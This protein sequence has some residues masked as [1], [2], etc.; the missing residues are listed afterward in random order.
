MDRA[1]FIR[2]IKVIKTF[3]TQAFAVDTW[4]HLWCPR[5]MP[6]VVLMIFAGLGCLAS[7]EHVYAEGSRSLYPS[8]YPA[9][10]WRAN[11]DFQPGQ[12]YIGKVRRSGFLYVYAQAG[13]YI[14]LG[15]RNRS[16]GGDIFIDNPQDFGTPGDEIYNATTP[17]TPE[18]SCSAG[19]TEPGTHYSGGTLGTVSTRTQELA[20]PN[21]AD[22]TVGVLNGFAP[23]AYQAPVNG[24]YGVLFNPAT[25]GDSPNGVIDPPALSNNSV[26][27]WD[28]TVRPD[29]TSTTD[30]NGRLFT[31]A[32]IG[33]TGGNS[34]PVY[35]T[36]YYITNDGYRYAQDLRGLDPNGYA[37]YA[38][39][40]GFLDNGQPLFKDLRGNEA[41]IT[42]LPPGVTT[43]TAQFPIFFTDV[44]P[45]NPHATEINRVL[46]ALSIPLTPPTP[47]VTSVSFTGYI[48]GSRT[49]PGAGGA[50]QFTT[51][52][53]ISYMIT[54]SRDGVD[55]NPE[56]VNNRTLTGIATTGTHRVPW[57]GK[58]NSGTNFPS[59]ETP[60]PFHIFGHNGDVHFPIIDA[61]NNPGGGPTITR[62][63]GLDAGDRTVYFDDRGY[64]TSSGTLVG[65]LNGT[66]CPTGT[67]A[68]PAP[69]VSLLGVD[70]LT[71]YR[72]WHA[73]GNSNTDCAASAGWG[74]AKGLNLWTFYSTTPQNSTLIIDPIIV[75]V[76]T[77]VSA[78]S[79]AT[80]GSPV[81]GTFS[82]ANN[83]NSSGLN[84]TYSMTMTPG[85][86]AVSF[87]NLPGGVTAAY[88]NITG[89][90]ALGGFPATLAAD[91]TFSG[92]TFGYT[93][94][95]T[96]PVIVSTDIST[97]SPEES[98]LPNNT[99]TA[100][101]GI[102]VTDVLTTVSV[103]AAAAAD[104]TVSGTFS[105]ANFGVNA[106][107]G[108]SYGATIGSVG[109]FPA[110]VT[111]TSLPTGV[112]ASYNN[113]NGQ[114]ALAGMPSTI[115]SGVSL[116]F[117]FN[118][119]APASGSVPLNT[120]IA[121][122]STDANQANNAATGTTTVTPAA[123][124]SITKTDGVSLVAAGGNLTYTMVV[125]NAGPSNAVGAS[126]TDTLPA[127][128][129]SASWSCAATGGSS[130]GVTNGSGNINTTVNLL[131]GGSATLTV[132][133]MLSGGASG[134]LVNTAGVATPGGVMDPNAG[135]NSATDT[136]TIVR[137]ADL[138]VT[139]T[140]GSLT[141]TPG[142]SLV[143]TVH[144]GNSGPSDVLGAT[145][146]DT[147]PL[148]TVGSWTA[149]FSG[150]ATGN[151][152]GTGNIME[153]ANIP[154][155]GSIIY[156]VTVTIPASYTG[157]LVN[158][159]TVSASAGVTDNNQ[160]NNT[161]TDT[162]TA[163]DSNTPSSG[164]DLTITKASHPHPYV[165]GSPFTYT[166]VVSNLGPRDVTSAEVKDALPSVCSTFTWQCVASGAGASCGTANGTGD[167]DALVTLP[168]GTHATF[169]VTGTMP[170]GTTGNL[171]NTATVTAP[172]GTTDPVVGN[173]SASD[174]NQSGAVAVPSLSQWGMIFLGVILF[175]V[176]VS[177]LMRIRMRRGA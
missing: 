139:K 8:T 159:A 138:W 131:S 144:V 136:D 154:A 118:Y 71:N 114:I 63:N 157:N 66:L 54:I 169:N 79:T 115:G 130:C 91:Q 92:M 124:L 1:M 43:Q 166:I 47:S 117:G 160:G 36:H 123:D 143:Y 19:S 94:P 73:G 83:G 50:F 25:S 77:A 125:T 167:I 135:N 90:V 64:R 173:N 149:V 23:C 29:V 48:G 129:T 17:G 87:S 107:S 24:V 161:A 46:D 6:V 37:L 45:M 86:G 26:S 170:G 177:R 104:T 78:P 72:L 103:P 74:D 42:T 68:A 85:L 93:A 51:T 151:G 41:L 137:V 59:S 39:T 134:W 31:Y 35:S 158:T 82:F 141:Y 119:P 32:F 168:A 27:V 22:D 99:A 69:P 150:G 95:A 102:G 55:Y 140:D 110:S 108:V 80:W 113:T 21:S 34:R 122:T 38:N 5:G 2:P 13:E 88:D 33:Y 153:F 30:I 44:S 148:G 57:D 75:D 147:M 175:F 10:G 56:N 133:A 111:F 58:D 61:E 67:P 100:T 3:L 101:T 112:T 132:N 28:V 109:N 96:G 7:P 49:T 116:I 164:A 172:G 156:T 70:S 128:L 12:L 20:G 145:V 65:N 176:G 121:T 9:G 14:L 11:L 89:L 105:F 165:P 81:Q 16:D 171:L 120:M 40:F 142:N 4:G 52:D 18:F 162:D 76:A 98:Y 174:S 60:Y 146:S 127:F 84:V 106:A 155:G 163:T 126:V 15:S 62:L 152:S 53:T 97:T